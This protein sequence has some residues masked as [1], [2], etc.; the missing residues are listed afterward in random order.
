MNN[1]LVFIISALQI[2]LIDIILS[3]DNIGVIALAIR[4]L[5]SRE[6]KIA[7][8]IGISCAIGLRIL[9]AS[10]VAIIMELEW[11]PI[12]LIGGILLLKITWDLVSKGYDDGRKCNVKSPPSFWKAVISIILADVSMSLD[13]VLAIGGAADGHVGLIAFGIALNIPIIF[14]GSQYVSAIM[15]KYKIAIYISGAVLLH[16]ALSMIL[17]DRLLAPYISKT[18]ALAVPWTAAGIS[19]IFGFIKKLNY[20]FK[21]YKNQRTEIAEIKLRK[22][23]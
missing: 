10:I 12:R 14:F 1:I 13:N 21:T 23:K 4:N 3:G 7:N 22:R 5:R 17:E 2:A 16:T 11:L 9:F 15:K 19:I 8:I 20:L 18:V 6:A